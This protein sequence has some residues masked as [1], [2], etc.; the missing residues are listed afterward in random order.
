MPEQTGIKNNY[1]LKIAI[2][3]SYTYDVSYFAYRLRLISI[4][5]LIDQ[6]ELVMPSW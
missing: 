1:L 4:V 6:V 2:T 5:P 3:F